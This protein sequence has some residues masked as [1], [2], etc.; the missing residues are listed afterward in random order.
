[1]PAV[2]SPGVVFAACLLLAGV[3]AARVTATIGA[4]YAVPQF[5][6]YHADTRADADAGALAAVALIAAALLSLLAAAIYVLLATLAA[7][8]LHPAR[9]IT[10]ILTA[11]T[12]VLTLTTLALDPFAPV[13]WFQHLTRVTDAA[14]LLFALAATVLLA[15]PA[16]NHWY[17]ARTAARHTPAP[18]PPAYPPSPHWQPPAPAPSSAPAPAPASPSAP[19]AESR[20]SAPAAESRPSAPAAESRAHSPAVE[21][22]PTSAS[23][24]QQ[25]AAPPAP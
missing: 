4:F 5:T 3:G 6:R 24:T 17:R 23:P 21:Q 18:P 25:Q 16:A 8:G 20:P 7:R 9:V 13:P 12:T 15:L 1:M 2:R 10:W 14:T 11:L 22:P 19:P